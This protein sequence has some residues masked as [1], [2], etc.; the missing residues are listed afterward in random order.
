MSEAHLVSALSPE[1]GC[2]QAFRGYSP[3]LLANVWI[4]SRT[5]YYDRFQF[6]MGG[7]RKSAEIFSRVTVD[8]T[9]IR[10]ERLLSASLDG[11]L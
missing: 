6:S 5:I 9:E 7:L 3:P 4:V 2:S 8:R 11:Y 10:T 1:T